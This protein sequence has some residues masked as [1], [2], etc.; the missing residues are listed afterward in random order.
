ME[1]VMD[2]AAIPRE[3]PQFGKSVWNIA[4]HASDVWPDSRASACSCA[5]DS[6]G[7]KGCGCVSSGCACLDCR[8]GSQ[9]LCGP[10]WGGQGQGSTWG[11]RG[12]GD[13]PQIGHPQVP[14][15]GKCPTECV[16]L[17]DQMLWQ[18]CYT[19]WNVDDDALWRNLVQ[20]CLNVW[21]W[22]RCP[23]EMGCPEPEC[24]RQPSFE[25]PPEGLSRV[26][27]PDVTDL[28]IQD[29]VDAAF[30]GVL[31]G[32]HYANKGGPLDFK[33]GGLREGRIVDRPG[34]PRDC[35]G[36][37][38]LCGRCVDNHV[39][40][41]IALGV[42]AGNVQ[43]ARM[44]GGGDQ[45]GHKLLSY[46][47]GGAYEPW[48]EPPRDIAAYRVGKRFADAYRFYANAWGGHP[49]SADRVREL[50]R[51]EF[52]SIFGEYANAGALPT[53]P[54]DPCPTAVTA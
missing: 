16:A 3:F 53:I 30:W 44:I 11:S 32:L 28:I 2:L 37:V 24:P 35:G 51:K 42:S 48:A 14:Q 8:G 45:L 5:G 4:R 7:C 50:M 25:P 29:Y 49:P 41:N 38:G 10:T 40:G 15:E 13:P 31:G 1:G 39:P 9:V 34:C 6:G 23:K 47:P 46:L 27:G 26:C 36:T 33:Q 52:C 22:P 18:C 20:G 19:Y 17:A 12:P 43:L 54:C 21:Y